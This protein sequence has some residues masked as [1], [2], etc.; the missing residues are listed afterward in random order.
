MFPRPFHRWKS[1]WLGVLVLVFL[2]WGW[3][4][5]QQHLDGFLWMAKR[6][7]FSAGQTAGFI[8]LAWSAATGARGESF[9]WIHDAAATTGEPLFPKAVNWESYPGQIQLTVAHW[10]LMG[11]LLLPW[12]IFLGWRFRRIRRM[13]REYANSLPV[14]L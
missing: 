12:S 13:A 5:S 2:G 1:F 11:L 3:G 10:F 14:G 4:R 9:I 6:F 7:H 8:E